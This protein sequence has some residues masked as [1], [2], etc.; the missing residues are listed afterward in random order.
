MKK[1]K[2]NKLHFLDNLENNPLKYYK[3]S[4]KVGSLN[5]NYKKINVSF[6]SN[7]TIEL[8]EPFIKIELIRR[9]LNPK[10]YFAPYDQVEQEI[11]NRNSTI[12]K[13]KNDLIV[14]ALTLENLLPD[15]FID[16]V[17]NNKKLQKNIIEIKKRV[18][19][20][21]KQI[22]NKNTL[23]KIIFFNFNYIQ[24]DLQSFTSTSSNANLD[25]LIE[26]INSYLISLTKK[27]DSLYIFDFKKVSQNLGLNNFFDKK[28]FLLSRMPFSLD[29]QLELSKSL[30]RYINA[31]LSVPKKCLVVDADNTIWGGVIGEEGIDGIKLGEDFPGNIYKSFH[32]FLLSLRKKGVLLALASKNNKKDVLEVFK[33]HDDCLLKEKHFSALEINWNDKAT[34]IKKIASNLNIGMDSIVFFD[35]NPVERELIRSKLPEVNVIEVSNNPLSYEG[36]IQDSEYFD[37]VFISKDDLKRPSMYAAKEKRENFLK[38][39]LNINDYLKSLKTKLVIGSIKKDSIKRCTQLINKTNQFNLTVKRKS[40]SDIQTIIKKGGVGMWVRVSDRF[41][42]NGLVGVGIATQSLNLD[43]WYIDT[44]LLSCRIIGRNVEDVF[45][46]ELI[47]KLKEK[48]RKSKFVVGE[49]IKGNKNLI[50]KNFYEEQGFKKEKSKWIKKLDSFKTCKYKNFIKVERKN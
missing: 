37:H 36:Q 22:K 34:S 7:Y 18:F 21:V 26:E 20:L 1:E 47:K 24:K 49:F 50:V 8:I 43:S 30:A 40:E 35:D 9:N 25:F 2:K 44:F 39:S 16:L 5:K 28:L 3:F 23:S 4:K 12:Y 27:F 31:I 11:Y 38:Q 46:F 45:L 6:L 13:E 42:D 29:S 19:N 33:K 48:N 41:G 14:L 17:Y 15:L 10:I 32:A